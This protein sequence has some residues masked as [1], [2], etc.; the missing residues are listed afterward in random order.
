MSVIRATPPCAAP[1]GRAG[2]LPTPSAPRDLFDASGKAPEK[3]YTVLVYMEGRHRLA[4]STDLALNKLEQLGSTDRMHV[5][6]QA[7]QEPTWLERLQTRFR[8]PKLPTR[9]YY[10]QADQDTRRV[11][12]PVLQE[13][14]QP[15][16]LDGQSLGEFVAWGMEKFPAR[17][18]IVIIK[19]HGAGFASLGEAV[20]LSARQTQQ[21]LQWAEQQTGRKPDLLVYDSCSM[22]QVEVAHQL[23]HQAEVVV[24]SQDDVKAVAFPYGTTLATLQQ[25]PAEA[26]SQQVGYALVKNYSQRVQKGM[27]SALDLGSMD[28]L[29]EKTRTFVDSVL[30]HQV[31]PELLYTALMDTAPM[32]RTETS[33]L[34]FNF[35]DLG[36]FLERVGGD[37]RFPDPVRLQAT[38]ARKQLERTVVSRYAS[39]DR[40][41]LRQPTGATTFLPWKRQDAPMKEAYAR[42]DWAQDTHWDRLLDYVLES[43]GAAPAAPSSVSLA[44]SVGKWGLFQYKKYISPHL[45]VACAYTPTCSQFAREAIE[46]HGF[47][48]GSKLGALRFFSCTGSAHGY[49]PLKGKECSHPEHQPVSPAEA[50]ATNFRQRLG[51]SLIH[52]P[53]AAPTTPAR[54]KIGQLAR[55]VGMLGGAAALGCLSGLAG[56]AVGGYVGWK[57]GTGQIEN[58]M[59]EMLE[60][61]NHSVVMGFK[62][63]AEPV[64]AP[65][66]QLHHKLGQGKLAGLVAGLAGLVGGAVLGGA[67]G[68]Y[69]G[70]RW[71]KTFGALW[72][73]NRVKEALGDLPQHPETA[74]ILEADYRAGS[75]LKERV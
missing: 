6:V 25:L 43:G 52:P 7:T 33:A 36:G 37:E 68:A 51:D 30:S 60:T 34:N 13:S 8:L 35:R 61:H 1:L 56:V 59:A 15:V 64:G 49:D 10:I 47:W 50:S 11:T 18:T 17:K 58:K 74:A 75:P 26:T 3:D 70:A 27:Q 69:E 71:G 9:R 57:S 24:G 42:L 44:D 16:P 66:L 5:V 41:I 2:F 62:H 4:H 31:R 29:A 67:G 53:E 40:R 28:D 46:T 22:Q 23:R 65:F 21:G 45:N 20:P 19:K 12:S 73:G 55:V 38:L 54:R 48:E 14:A 39:N 63:I 72:L 32:E